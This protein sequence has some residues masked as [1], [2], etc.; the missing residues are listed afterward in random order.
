MVAATVH[1]FLGANGRRCASIYI[2]ERQQ[3]TVLRMSDLNF[4]F[5]SSHFS[6]SNPVEISSPPELAGMTL[7]KRL[8]SYD[9]ANQFES[10]QYVTRLGSFKPLCWTPI[11]T[12]LP[13]SK[14]CTFF[15]NPAVNVFGT[16]CQT[17]G[18]WL[19]GT[20][21]QECVKKVSEGPLPFSHFMF[22]L[23]TFL[24]VWTRVTSRAF[25][26]IEGKSRKLRQQLIWIYHNLRFYAAS[27]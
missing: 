11:N 20:R 3:W 7:E 16:F 24:D 15:A 8:T 4:D 23:L 27:M 19:N 25:I 10:F 9:W 21:M 18:E 22:T 26:L 12:M 5:S 13:V 2:V 17:V 14:C 1:Q 6:G